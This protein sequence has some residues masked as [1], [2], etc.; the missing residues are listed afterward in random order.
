LRSLGLAALVALAALLSN[1]WFSVGY[2]AQ[3]TLGQYRIAS[4]ARPIDEALADGGLSER[5]R[6]LLAV[7]PAIKR[8]GQA[9]GLRPTPS[10]A[11]FAD[12]HRPAAAWV[13]QGC[14]PLSFE[15][16]RW[17]FPVIGSVPYLGFFDE[18]GAKGYA[19]ALAAKEALDVD[20]RTASAFSTLGWFHDP[21]LSTMIVPGDDAAGRLAN[22]VLHESVHATLYLNDQSAFNES[23]ASFVADRLTVPWL[24]SAFGATAPET[25]AWVT[26]HARERARMARLHDTYLALDTVYRSSASQRDKQH[27]KARILTALEA[28][29]RSPRPLNNAAIAG[30]KTY[31]TGLPAFV[32]ALAA[33]GG[34]WPRLLRTLSTLRDSDFASPQQDEFDEVIDRLLAR[35]CAG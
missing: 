16:R 33:C 34:S 4:A 17:S 5:T 9:Q 12:L 22:V 6:R 30:F 18:A 2:L 20:V 10:Y 1:S 27:R 21:V 29:L 7:V 8:Y 19:E 35:G 32:R 28:E 26:A 3:A 24:T 23:L 31:D 14:A 11:R 15:V 25:I 13:V